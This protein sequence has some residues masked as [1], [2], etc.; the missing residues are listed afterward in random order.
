MCGASG[1]Q[2]MQKEQVRVSVTPRKRVSGTNRMGPPSVLGWI[3]NVLS[4]SALSQH[5]GKE[6]DSGENLSTIF[7]KSPRLC[8]S[9][10]SSR[11]IPFQ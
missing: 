8:H 4:F 7:F 1:T 10:C 5:F 11:W 2:K 9:L 6:Q 3:C